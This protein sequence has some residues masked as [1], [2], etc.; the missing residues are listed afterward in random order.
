MLT[1]R[2]T[3][4]KLL[5]ESSVE[6]SSAADHSQEDFTVTSETEGDTTQDTSLNTFISYKDRM[7]ET[8]AALAA[9]M[10]KRVERLLGKAHKNRDKLARQRDEETSATTDLETLK[11]TQATLEQQKQDFEVLSQDLYETETN[12]TAIEEDEA[13][14]DE[15]DRAMTLALRDCKYLLSQRSIHS[16]ISSLEAVIRGLTAA[17]EASP[18]NDHSLAISSSTPK[19]RNW[20][21]TC[22]YLS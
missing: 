19:S 5:E 12:P 21:T 18:D 6:D 11:E 22:T 14:A 20:R 9:P 7:D 4:K 2:A 3:L 8:T 13:K 16:N 1:R 17:Y 10:R 15:F